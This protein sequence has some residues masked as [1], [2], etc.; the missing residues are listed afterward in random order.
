[1]SFF[2]AGGVG[3]ISVSVLGLVVYN[4]SNTGGKKT[5]TYIL[6]VA[7]FEVDSEG[8]VLT[9]SL[10]DYNDKLGIRDEINSMKWDAIK[11]ISYSEEL[12]S[13]CIDG[14]GEKKTIWKSEKRKERSPR[15]KAINRI[16]LYLPYDSKDKFI[17]LFMTYGKEIE[18]VK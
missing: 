18:M 2:I 8:V 7:F 15:K 3:G 5:S 14:K 10:I 11:G 16:I 1:M 13:I 17:H 9:H 6:T 12:N 4:L